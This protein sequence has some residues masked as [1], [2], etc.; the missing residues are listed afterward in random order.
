VK[1]KNTCIILKPFSEWRLELWH[2][3]GRFKLLGPFPNLQGHRHRQRIQYL[4]SNQ[5]G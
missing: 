2:L 5:G 1:K 4:M 3:P